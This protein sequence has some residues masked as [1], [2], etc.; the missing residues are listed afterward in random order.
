MN[1]NFVAQRLGDID[2]I[3]IVGSHFE[4]LP[5]SWIPVKLQL[6]SRDFFEAI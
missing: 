1:T 3:Y 4:F 2:N 6:V 5:P